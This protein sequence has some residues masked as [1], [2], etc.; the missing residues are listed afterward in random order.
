MFPAKVFH[1]EMYA[2]LDGQ[3]FAGAAPD[4]HTGSK[5]F[6]QGQQRVVMLFWSRVYG[7]DCALTSWEDSNGVVHMV[8]GRH[9]SALIVLLVLP[10]AVQ[11]LL[12]LPAVCLCTVL[13]AFF[14]CCCLQ[15]LTKSMGNFGFDIL[16]ALVNDIAPAA[17]VRH[18]S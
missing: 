10:L 1:A 4:R 14:A 3:A 8:L 15:E 6:R 17:K 12:P 16:Q 18:E 7:G 9:L 2:V 5:L 13:R 11:L